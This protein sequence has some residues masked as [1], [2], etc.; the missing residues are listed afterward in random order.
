V[1][2]PTASQLIGVG[3]A[4]RVL[5]VD[6]HRR[7]AQGGRPV[8]GHRRAD[9]ARGVAD[10]EAHRLAA[11]ANSAAMMRSPSFSLI[12]IVDDEDGPARGDGGDGLRRSDRGGW[13]ERLNQS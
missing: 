10:E 6:D 13:R 4:L 5:V 3:R 1:V 2:T 9:D 8:G 7:Q 12:L 11:S